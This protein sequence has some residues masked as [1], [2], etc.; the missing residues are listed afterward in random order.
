MTYGEILADFCSGQAISEPPSAA[1]ARMKIYALDT[2]A[3]TLAG[4]TADS[5]QRVMKAFPPG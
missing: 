1:I 5:S 4:A 3:V 2:L